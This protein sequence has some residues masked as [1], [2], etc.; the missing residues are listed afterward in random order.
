MDNEFHPQQNPSGMTISSP[1]EHGFQATHPSFI[2]PFILLLHQYC[3][4]AYHVSSTDGHILLNECVLISFSHVSVILTDNIDSW[5]IDRQLS[6]C[7]LFPFP[8]KVE[9][10]L[11]VNL[12][13][14]LSS[15][16][17][18]TFLTSIKLCTHTHLPHDRLT[19]CQEARIPVPSGGP[20]SGTKNQIDLRQINGRKS[21][22]TA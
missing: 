22:L 12:W 17:I 8:R 15:A 19:Y 2:Y 18:V 21:N 6:Y 16:I 10:T 11:R 3:L 13:F 20:L 7:Q 14:P 9:T 5:H 4:S 1:Q